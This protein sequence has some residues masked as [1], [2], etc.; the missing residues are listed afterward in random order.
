MG[1]EITKSTTTRLLAVDWSEGEKDRLV[2]ELIDVMAD[3]GTKENERAFLSSNLGKE[4]KGLTARKDEL[5]KRLQDGEH[6]EIPCEVTKN[7]T[8][9]ELLVVRID[10]N[11][12]V[13]RRA[14]GIN[15]NPNVLDEAVEGD[16]VDGDGEPTPPDSS[17]EGTI[18]EPAQEDV[19][20]EAVEPEP[21]NVSSEVGDG[22]AAPAL[23][24]DD[25]ASDEET[26]MGE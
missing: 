24:D 8:T 25:F 9:N 4:I 12:E 23:D 7:Y 14:M 19:V 5:R 20:G 21:E 16:N 10:T 18:E 22:E 11:E 15:D 17:S 1:P 3:I 13:E 2:D 26:F 6:R